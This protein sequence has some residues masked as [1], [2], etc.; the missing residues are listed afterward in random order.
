MSFRPK[1]T[2]R[3]WRN[4]FHWKGIFSTVFLLNIFIAVLIWAATNSCPSILSIEVASQ[5]PC[6]FM[7]SFGR[8]IRLED[9]GR[10]SGF[11][12]VPTDA[13]DDRVSLWEL[14]NTK[15]SDLISAK[16]TTRFFITRSWS[17]QTLSASTDGKY[18][19]Q[20]V[21]GHIH[22]HWL[23]YVVFTIAQLLFF[24][25]ASLMQPPRESATISTRES[26]ACAISLPFVLLIVLPLQT[27]LSNTTTFTF[28]LGKLLAQLSFQFLVW[29]I[30]SSLFA[31][32]STRFSG[33][34]FPSIFVT[35]A[36][37][38]YLET[39]LLSIGCSSLDGET[40]AYL[41]LNRGIFDAL[42]IILVSILILMVARKHSLFYIAL[43]IMLLSFV[44]I[45][46]SNTSNGRTNNIEHILPIY[47]NCDVVKSSKYSSNKNVILFMLD[48]IST[49]VLL[50]VLQAAPEITSEFNGFTVCTN[51]VGMCGGTLFAVPSILT[52]RYPTEFSNTDDFPYLIYSTNTF[53]KPYLD[54]RAEVMAAPGS[55]GTGC[56]TLLDSQ[57]NATISSCDENND[58]LH[59]RAKDQQAWNLVEMIRFRIT[60]YILKY[61]VYMMTSVG[62]SGAGSFDEG[63]TFPILSS[64]EISNESPL[65]L[66]Y[67]HTAGSHPPLGVDRNGLNDGHIRIGYEAKFEKTW[68]SLSK[69]ALLLK[70]LKERGIYDNSY[71][72]VTADHG[73]G[74]LYADNTAS[75]HDTPSAAFPFLM[76]KPI[77]NNRPLS[78]SG[79][80][81]CH[82]KLFHLFSKLATQNIDQESTLQILE[83]HN[84]IYRAADGLAIYDYI[85]SDDLSFKKTVFSRVSVASLPAIKLDHK[86]SFCS[87]NTGDT[88]PAE[89]I[90]A[91]FW[92]AVGPRHFSTEPHSISF[93]VPNPNCEYRVE[94]EAMIERIVASSDENG[95]SWSIYDSN[96]SAR[97]STR[98][99]GKNPTTKTLSLSARS[100]DSAI[101]RIIGKSTGTGALLSI[102]VS[103]L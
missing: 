8:V 39:G 48:S 76:F 70:R 96:S 84:R 99:E 53:I 23:T 47:D 49:P 83:G 32:L 35:L 37:Y 40:G 51:N 85:F 63:W 4:A 82:S 56:S 30:A 94:I 57:R 90:G 27:Y 91:N 54:M 18:T 2:L 19:L 29:S 62:W 22:F 45:F 28:P 16:I 103:Q 80:P 33:R 21:N 87:K 68:Y 102:K 58:V 3:E 97:D 41:N 6:A 26:I 65:A 72:V 81:T 17:S 5:S 92:D 71:I 74:P 12:L 64:A 38:C 73:S 95:C 77:G 11:T 66:Q 98:V 20:D 1:S 61:Y 67:W 31:V 25:A 78:Y 44:S 13:A 42:A 43:G 36:L 59:W 7:T 93:K 10:Q 75:A 50:S 86:Y 24:A 79:T 88:L 60:P 9:T 69:L 14:S 52:G 46:D 15:G 55:F 89:V 101:V 34:L 100:D